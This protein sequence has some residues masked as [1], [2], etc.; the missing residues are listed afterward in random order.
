MVTTEIDIDDLIDEE[1][2]SLQLLIK[3]TQNVCLSILINHKDAAG[4]RYFRS[5][6]S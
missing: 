3:V 1:R 5:Y 2:L 4:R 6:N